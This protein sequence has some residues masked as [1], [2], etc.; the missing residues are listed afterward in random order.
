VGRG[1]LAGPVTVC[2]F[3]VEDEEEVARKIFSNTIKDS[4]K[5]SKSLRNNIY[6]TIRENRLL[7]S[8]VEYAIAERSAKFI[9]QHGIVKAIDACVHSCLRQLE[10]KG[11]NIT[12]IHVRLDGGLKVK[13]LPVLQSTHIKGDEQFVEIALASILAKVHRDTYMERLGKRCKGYKWEENA[14]YGTKFHREAI[15]S[16]G[17]T[18]YHRIT[19]LKAFELFDK[20]EKLIDIAIAKLEA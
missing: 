18:K 16:L 13:R 10:E 17:V 2:A 3:Y 15:K 8:R 11:I 6:Q 7:E 4:K 14:G 20:A 19:Y 9:D 1:P 12:Q 5:L